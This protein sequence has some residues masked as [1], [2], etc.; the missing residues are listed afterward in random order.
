MEHIATQNSFL[1]V[2][3]K[4]RI[5]KPQVVNLLIDKKSGNK[6]KFVISILNNRGALQMDIASNCSQIE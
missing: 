4:S 1:S 5:G 6:I 2:K 3:I